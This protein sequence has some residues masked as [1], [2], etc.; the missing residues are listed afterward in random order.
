LRRNSC[1]VQRLIDADLVCTEGAAALENKDSLAQLG[2]F[3][4]E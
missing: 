4:G 1:F 3:A 2:H